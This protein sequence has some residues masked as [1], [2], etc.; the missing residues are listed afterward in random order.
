MV[1]KTVGPLSERKI[2]LG[3]SEI[4]RQ[5]T[6]TPSLYLTYLAFAACMFMTAANLSW[7]P[8]YFLRIDHLP[9]E[10]A[11]LK[12]SLVMLVSIL[13]FPLGGYIADRWRKTR[14]NARLV[15]PAVSSLITFLLFFIAFSVLTGTAQFLT[16][17]VGGIAASA[18]SPSA[19][20]VTQDVVHPGLRA[21]SYSFCVI[22]QNLLGSSLGPLFVGM[23]S[24]RY[25]I[26]TAMQIV[27]LFSLLAAILFVAASFYYEKDL[28]KVE[29]VALAAE[30]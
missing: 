15:F 27:P 19:I 20:A 22:S 21:T 25:D 24:D 16:L 5:F 10:K 18:F 17:L 29:R 13:G 30:P 1:E 7:L 28:A 4:L 26:L 6:A 9:V 11:A 2:R 14:V 23:L 8:T 3:R 12:G